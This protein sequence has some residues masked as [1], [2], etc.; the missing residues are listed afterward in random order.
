MQALRKLLKSKKKKRDNHYE[1]NK[2]QIDN[3]GNLEN[4]IITNDNHE[5]HENH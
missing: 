3:N 1:N 2:I 5:N 4:H